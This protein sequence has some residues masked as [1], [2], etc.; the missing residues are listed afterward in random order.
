METNAHDVVSVV[1]TT[2]NSASTIREVLNALL[3]QEYPLSLI[4]VI[5][6]DD[7]SHD[8]TLDIVKEFEGEHRGK[9][10]DFKIIVHEENLGVSRARNDGIK[11]SRG[12]HVLI[13]D[14]DVVLPP[15]A[16][17]EMMNFLSQNPQVGCCVLLHKPDADNVVLKWR[18][19]VDYGR[20]RYV[21]AATSAALIKRSI[22]EKTG[23]Y[24]ETLGP[25]FSSNEDLEFSARI[26]R[27]GY[28]IVQLGSVVAYHLTEKRKRHIE[29]LVR[30]DDERGRI[31]TSLLMRIY[32]GYFGKKFGL[33]WFIFL[34]A[35]PLKIKLRYIHPLAFPPLA[36]MLAISLAL[37]SVNLL[38]LITLFLM[39]VIFLDV[40]RDYY[41][42]R[43]IHKSCILALFATINRSIKCLSAVI[44]GLKEVALRKVRLSTM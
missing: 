1:I 9:F 38:T 24:N 2:Y 4:E 23:L 18:Y 42:P 12:G 44:H 34:R 19:D 29:Y 37:N 32:A 22:L 26:W 28:K 13:L 20:N 5:V 7:H 27:A 21:M 41:N 8:N 39:L 31:T 33:T 3:T 16:I 30:G 14:S 40:F 11:A 25:P 6:V 17:R 36:L 10:Y 15:N 43:H 35:L